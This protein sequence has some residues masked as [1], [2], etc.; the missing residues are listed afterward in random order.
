MHHACSACAYFTA[1][2]SAT[3][4]PTI[5]DTPTE[6]PTGTLPP[7]DTPTATATATDTATP[8]ATD[9]ATT[10]PTDT[11]TATANDTA[12]ATPTPPPRVTDTATPTN[13]LTAT[14]TPTATHTPTAPP[15]YTPTPTDTPTLPPTD[16]PTATPTYTPTPTATAVPLANPLPGISTNGALGLPVAMTRTLPVDT[17]GQPAL[18]PSRDDHSP[19]LVE[20]FEHS[21]LNPAFGVSNEASDGT[22][23]IW[24]LSTSQAHGGKSSVGVAAGATTTAAQANSG[25]ISTWFSNQQALDLRGLQQA[26]VEY[27]LNT[28]LPTTTTIFVG[29]STDNLHFTGAQ[30]SGNSG[31][32][33]RMKI[34][35]HNYI[36]QRQVYSAWVVQGALNPG[37][38]QGVGLEDLAVWTYT[39]TAP[40]QTNPTVSNGSF[41]TGNQDFW[42]ASNGVE[43]IQATNPVT[44]NY[45]VRL[46]GVNNV[47]QTFDQRIILPKDGIAHAAFD[48]WIN[49]FGEE[50]TLGA[51]TLCTGLYGALGGEIDR[52][53]RLVDLG[54]LDG[55][56]AY[57][58]VFAAK[59]WWQVDYPISAQQWAALR[60]KTI[61]AH[62]E[63][64]TNQQLT[65]TVYLDDIAL[66][67]TTGGSAGDAEE[68][69]DAPS[70]AISVT[71]GI[72]LTDLTIDPDLDAD[73]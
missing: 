32:W 41:E 10:T 5:T 33:Q 67:V 68:P 58:P 42:Q 25:R 12:T 43:V 38:Q 47:V 48:Y 16:T 1:C 70:N 60:G 34:D 72:S 26:D 49:L 51:D 40:E 62:F 14:N 57:S 7:T 2:Y 18:P 54:C 63:L 64:K 3:D 69:N 56:E 36:G 73:Y 35:L 50:T 27:F 23:P 71:T 19:D 52:S 37:R 31:G 46:G 66:N 65:T 53:N 45:V 24:T 22:A 6:T 39:A 9:T 28:T 4:T 29:V 13:T 61:F 15:T 17:A 20:G 30:W 55:V 11:A 8:T 44:G 59:G 21:V